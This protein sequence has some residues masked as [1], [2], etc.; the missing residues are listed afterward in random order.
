MHPALN[1]FWNLKTTCRTTPGTTGF[2]S[3][4]TLHLSPTFSQ[5]VLRPGAAPGAILLKKK[6]ASYANARLSSFDGTDKPRAPFRLLAT[7][8]SLL[9]TSS[10]G[11]AR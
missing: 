3:G 1:L 9:P 10:P 2:L 6:R 8:Y 4:T 11:G 5:V 7:R